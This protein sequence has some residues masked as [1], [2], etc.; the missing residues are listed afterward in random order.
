VKNILILSGQIPHSVSAGNIQLLRLLS[1]YPAEKLLVIGPAVPEGAKRLACRYETLVPPLNR[2]NSTRLHLWRRTAR[3]LGLLSM[4]S[5]QEVEPLVGKFQPELV[6]S[7]METSDYYE[8]AEKYAQIKGIPLYLIVHDT[9]EDFEKVF[10][11][12]K[13]AQFKKDK[14]IYR[15]AKERF[16]VSPEMAEF[17]EKRFGVLGKVLY[18]IPD[19]EIQPR[20]Q[21]LSKALRQP[22]HLTIGYAGSM[23]YG[24]AEM[25]LESLPLLEKAGVRLELCSPKPAGKVAALL[26]SPIVKWHGYLP[27][28]EAIQRLQERCDVLWLPYLEPAGENERLY[29]THFPSKLCD[30]LQ[31]GMAIWVT[32]PENATG[33]RW[34]S[35]QG[36]R[37]ATSLAQLLERFRQN[38]V[39]VLE[40][41]RL[42]FHLKG[43]FGLECKETQEF[44]RHLQA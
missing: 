34:W 9:N 43:R 13:K 1:D 6:L 40:D 11:W 33:V 16:C 36:H 10:S 35:G 28:R 26:Q 41:A 12:A 25:M 20:P 2:L 18:P 5:M 37:P 19:Q 14:R 8:L 39:T 29:R 31:T 4:N 7:L 32:G 44:F 23:A 21:E 24:Y 27:S 15:S 30:Y 3:V 38:P 42:A 22:P 17:N